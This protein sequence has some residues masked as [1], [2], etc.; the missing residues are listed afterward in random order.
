MD[1]ESSISSVMKPKVKDRL[2]TR[3]PADEDKYRTQELRMARIID[4]KQKF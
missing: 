1:D 4:E 2:H 3:P